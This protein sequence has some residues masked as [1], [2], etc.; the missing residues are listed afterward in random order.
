MVDLL[1]ILPDDNGTENP[2]GKVFNLPC[3][4][5]ATVGDLFDVI[6]RRLGAVN[7]R[8]SLEGPSGDTTAL[9][10]LDPQDPTTIGS[11][12]AR[13]ARI[14]VG[15]RSGQC[16]DP[17]LSAILAD[18]TRIRH[19]CSRHPTQ[20][21][22]PSAVQYLCENQAT[23]LCF[24][25]QLTSTS[26]EVRRTLYLQNRELD[27]SVIGDDCAV[28][29]SVAKTACMVETG[30]V[31]VTDDDVNMMLRPI[32]YVKYLNCDSCSPPILSPILLP[33]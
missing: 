25:E 32:E 18:L 20:K 33:N 6:R 23:I 3:D 19:W 7:F 21:M 16:Y 27:E 4:E 11:R 31:E 14:I 1:F 12:V 30:L 15:W 13:G 10:R 29:I 28:A 2:F 24:I 17:A 5:D 8:L 9:G 22:P 26:G